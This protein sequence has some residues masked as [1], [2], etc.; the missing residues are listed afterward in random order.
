MLIVW[1]SN[2]GIHPHG[3]RGVLSL[4]LLCKAGLVNLIDK[5]G[6]NT[7]KIYRLSEKS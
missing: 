1:K 6:Y 2:N 7:L 4:T 5:N 3:E